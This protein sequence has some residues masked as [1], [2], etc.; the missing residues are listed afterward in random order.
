MPVI[1]DLLSPTTREQDALENLLPASFRD[2]KHEFHAPLNDIPTFLH[3]D[4]SVQRLNNIQKWLWLAGRP[5]PPRA[6]NYQISVSR[7]IIVDEKVDM[8]LVWGPGRRIHIKPLPAYLLDSRFWSSH[9]ACNRDES[10]C[11]PW[12]NASG[13]ASGTETFAANPTACPRAELGKLALGFLSSY[14]ALIEHPSDFLIAKQHALVPESL[15]WIAWSGLV[16]NLLRTDIIN[17]DSVNRRYQFG[18][19]RLGRLNKIYFCQ[20]RSVLRGYRSKYQTYDELFH[21]YLTPITAMTVYFALVLTAMQVGLAT[22]RLQYNGAFQNASYGFTVFSILGPILLVFIVILI[23][24]AHLGANFLATLLFKK[25][26][27]IFFKKRRV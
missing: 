27:S 9:L 25:E 13:S 16:R 18:E 26:R 17:P 15:S 8:H 22:E 10:D 12:R 4:L 14:I 23:A 6:L 11:C 5:M 24:I 21:A 2:E 3:Q 1:T 7:Q 19:L 20:R